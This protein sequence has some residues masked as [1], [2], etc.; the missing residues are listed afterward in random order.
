MMWWVLVWVAFRFPGFGFSG[1][2]LKW[3]FGRYRSSLLGR[4]GRRI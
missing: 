3:L 2:D 4:W 1:Y